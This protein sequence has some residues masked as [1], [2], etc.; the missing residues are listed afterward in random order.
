MTTTTTGRLIGFARELQ[1]ATTFSEVLRTSQAEIAATLGYAHAWLF[2]ADAE[3]ATMLRLIDMAG[4]K[5]DLALEDFAQ[6]P[7]EGDAMIA[8]ILRGD[9][10]VVVEDARTDPR[11]NKDIVA[12]VGNRTIVN[13]PLRLLDRPLGIFG[14]GTFADEGCR[15]PSQEEVDYLVA[16]TSQ[17][18]VAVAR[19]RLQEER[20]SAAKVRARLEQRIQQMQRLDSLGLLAAGVA[21]D[22]NNLLTIVLGS[23]G[24]LRSVLPTGSRAEIRNI[25]DAAE[26][27]AVLARQLLAM[28]RVQQLVRAPTDVNRLLR[29]LLA[30]LGGSFPKNVTLELLEGSELPRVSADESQLQQVFMNLCL[31]AR[32]AMPHG[33]RLT[34]AAQLA[35]LD[36]AYV[37]EHPWAKTGKYVLVRVTDT[38]MGMSKEVVDHVFE[39]FFTTKPV[40][41]QSGSGLGLAV[42]YGIV[43]QHD[44]LM[45]CHSEP[46]IG[47]SFDVY[48]P[49]P[50]RP[51]ASVGGLLENATT[52][53]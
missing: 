28:G 31:N 9:A 39:P 29:S 8:E 49:V 45:H 24:A 7:V 43:R 11:T 13:I 20:A 42:A 44:G 14:T 23:A 16:M 41:E 52:G 10:P 30:L 26:R 25:E 50:E 2:I 18:V 4:A 3:D 15:P 38:G 19:I 40:T 27:A 17:I 35:T 32:E 47:T 37:A 5:R 12:Q 21:H 36:G 51:G 46:G 53:V 34:V 48:L 1:S 33:G 22:F 6:L